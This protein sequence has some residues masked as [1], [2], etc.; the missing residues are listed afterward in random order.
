VDES[1]IVS[2]RDIG[3]DFAVGIKGKALMQA[4]WEMLDNR[5]K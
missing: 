5:A 4:I 2:R 3:R 1:V